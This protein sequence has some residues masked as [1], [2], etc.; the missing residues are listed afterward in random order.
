M[1]LL[2]FAGSLAGCARERV[3]VSENSAITQPT[4]DRTVD[5]VIRGLGQVS[6]T[7]VPM[8]TVAVQPALATIAARQIQGQSVNANPAPAAPVAPVTRQAPAAVAPAA[9]ASGSAGAGP[10][11]L[12]T[13]RP[14]TAAPTVVPLRP[15]APAVVAT[16]VAPPVRPVATPTPR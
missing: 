5:A 8:A 11:A 12:P 9:P 6:V 1:A 13:A 10:P 16:P 14:A 15:T 4:P 2:V 3:Y 7:G